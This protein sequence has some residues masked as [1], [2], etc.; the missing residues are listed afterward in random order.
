MIDKPLVPG[1][2]DLYYGMPLSEHCMSAPET[3][4]VIFN[5]IFG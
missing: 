5:E 4:N 2:R 1:N 3:L